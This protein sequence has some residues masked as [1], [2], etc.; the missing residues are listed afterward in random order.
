MKKMKAKPRVLRK[1]MPN[2]LLKIVRATCKKYGAIRELS[3]KTGIEYA[4]LH[5]MVVNGKATP[6]NIKKIQKALAA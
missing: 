5:T 6:E 2:E 3:D 4:N 1:K